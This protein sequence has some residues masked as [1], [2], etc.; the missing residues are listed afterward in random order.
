MVYKHRESNG[1]VD[2]RLIATKAVL[3]DYAQDSIIVII[4]A[5]NEERFIASV[6]FQ[7]RPFADE[8][9]VVDDGSTDRTAQLAEAAGATVLRLDSNS[10]K[11]AAL[12]EGFA[13]ATERAPSAVVCLD[14]DSQH[15]PSDIPDLVKPILAGGADVV[16][17]SRFLSTRSR[18]PGWRKVGQHTLTAMTNGMSGTNVTDSQSG[19][20]AFSAKAVRSMHFS[21]QGLS[22]ESEMQFMF[23]PAGLRVTEVPISVRYQDGA[24]RNPVVHGMQVIDALVSMVARRRPLMFFTAP[25][26]A[27]ASFGG[28]LGVWVAVVMKNT[29]TLLVGTTM[30]TVLLLVVGLLL[31][32]TGVI[33]HS[34]GH[35]TGRLREEVYDAVRAVR[36]EAQRGSARTT[37]PSATHAWGGRGDQ[38]AR[39]LRAEDRVTVIQ[40]TGTNDEA[41]V[42]PRR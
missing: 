31:G 38:V 14:G 10:G 11:A 18:I 39:D 28:V 9:V 42:T 7:T 41:P 1:A 15:E 35:L 22:V 3:P 20:R 32:V 6:V 21:S 19:F 23:E 16:I 2:S 27:L 12:N 17:G 26:V 34:L 13:Y 40:R 4:P 36:D 37:Y 8:V 29:G 30:L 33:L 25:G 24:K 5:F